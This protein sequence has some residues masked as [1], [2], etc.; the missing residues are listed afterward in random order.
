M[1]RKAS[2][3]L[4]PPDIGNYLLKAL[5]KILGS[6]ISAATDIISFLNT[7]TFL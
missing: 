6:P 3:R 7:L 5:K 1:P 4:K 2:I